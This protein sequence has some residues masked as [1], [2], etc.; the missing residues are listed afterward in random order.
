MREAKKILVID[1]DLDTRMLLSR[2]LSASSYRVIE[3][4]DGDVGMALAKQDQVDLI[5]LD[6]LMPGEDGIKVYHDLR[7]D[8]QTQSIPVLFLTALAENSALTERSLELMALAKHGL[9]LD[10]Y[11]VVMGKPYDPQQLLQEIRR[12]LGQEKSWV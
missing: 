5:I 9:E 1:D 6:L 10:Q 3:A 7:Q 4:P 11:F 8:P 12:L 2:R